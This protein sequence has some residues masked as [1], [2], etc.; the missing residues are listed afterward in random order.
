MPTPQETAYPRL[1]TH[2]ST[3]DLALFYTPSADEQT[4]VQQSARG[5]VARLGLLIL[6]K[7][8]QRL[9]YFVSLSQ[10]PIGLVEY[11]A[12]FTLTAVPLTLGAAYDGSGTRRRHVRLIRQRLEVQPYGP[13]AR[14][15]MLQAMREAARTKED[16]ADLI[17]VAIEELIRQ[18]FELPVFD[19]LLRGARHVRSLVYRQF[20]RQ[21]E[22][23]LSREEQARLDT[24][25]VPE[26]ES[27]FTPWNTLKQEPG[28]PTLMHLKFWLDRQAWLSGYPLGPQVLAGLPAM[29]IRHF[30]HEAKTL[31]AARMRDMEPG[32][33][34]TLAA[35]L[36]SV[37]AARILDDLAEM[38]IKRI[39]ALHHK[40]KEALADYQVRQ[41]QR[42]D[43]L[44]RMLRDLVTAYRTEGTAE[45]KV[46]AMEALLL[47][48]GE[49]VLQSC[50]D[51]LAYAGDNYL[52]F[53]WR[54]FKSH[55]A[56]LFRLLRVLPVRATTQ[57]T[58]FEGVIGFLLE[59]ESRIGEW[60]MVPPETDLD[61]T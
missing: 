20:Y 37:Q 44:V 3:R 53:L 54:F 30:A 16:L 32:K 59:R 2:F 10:V 23:R 5:E 25:F 47:N 13:E 48:G 61:L 24:L 46:E 42:T 18:R 51:H 40:G 55:R 8:F 33:R 27:R 43:D 50:E 14:Q 1:K 60:L 56:V 41:R 29:K 11:L 6:L 28:N 34:W 58:A 38:L 9:G 17:N 7:T 35:A 15:A 12:T 4:F 39:S 36:L 31:D 45:A 22:T 21:V 57:D 52:P 49:T 26:P 19:T